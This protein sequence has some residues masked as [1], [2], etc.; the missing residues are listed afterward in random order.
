MSTSSGSF[1]FVMV[2]D[3]EEREETHT[4]KT[5]LLYDLP[6]LTELVFTVKMLTGIAV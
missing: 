6:H 4:E 3:R 1:Q 2:R 5:M